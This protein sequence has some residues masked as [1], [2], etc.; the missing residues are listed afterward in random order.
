[1]NLIKESKDA[2]DNVVSLLFLGYR[3]Y[4]VGI[5]LVLNNNGTTLKGGRQYA[6]G[7]EE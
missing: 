3:V 4:L 6:N 7:K 1:M 5:D 2:T